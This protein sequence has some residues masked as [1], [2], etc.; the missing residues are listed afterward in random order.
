MLCVTQTFYGVFSFRFFHGSF[1]QDSI[2]VLSELKSQD[3]P[4]CI[5]SSRTPGIPH[6]SSCGIVQQ[7]RFPTRED[8]QGVTHSE[9]FTTSKKLPSLQTFSLLYHDVYLFFKR[10]ALF[11]ANYTTKKYCSRMNV[12]KMGEGLFHKNCEQNRSS[13]FWVSFSWNL[14]TRMTIFFCTRVE[15]KKNEL[16]YRL[17]FLISYKKKKC[18]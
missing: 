9:T 6:L 3:P 14:I 12:G 16:H 8:F 7:A 11:R 1:Q 13:N 5:S 4:G 2:T 10:R 15:L 17:N 18:K